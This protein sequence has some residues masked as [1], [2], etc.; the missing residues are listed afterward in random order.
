MTKITVTFE[1]PDDAYNE[2][3]NVLDDFANTLIDIGVRNFDT[4]EE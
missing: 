2:Y 1:V 4:I 3:E